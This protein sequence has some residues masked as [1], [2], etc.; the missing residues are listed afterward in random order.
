[1]TIV[2]KL[3]HDG[4]EI[5][6]MSDNLTQA[7]KQ[8]QANILLCTTQAG[9]GH[10]TSS[11]SAVHIMTSLFFTSFKFNPQDP[12]DLRNDRLIFSK[13]HASPLYYSLYRA[14]GLIAQDELMTF[15]KFGSRIEGH[16]SSA[17]PFC[18]CLTGS[19][20]Q[21]VGVA[22]GE[23]IALKKQG[24]DARVYCLLGDSELAEGSCY[25]AFNS[26]VYNKLDNLVYIVDFN[27]LGQRGATQLEHNTELL[28]KRLSSFGLEVF[29]LENGNNLNECLNTLH[30]LEF[31]TSSKPKVIIAKTQK[32]YGV[33]FLAD[34]E[35]FHGKALSKEDC[36]RALKEIGSVDMKAVYPTLLLESQE[37]SRENLPFKRQYPEDTK[38]QVQT[39]VWQTP[40]SNLSTRQAYGAYL[41]SLL[42]K[43]PAIMV[44][45]AEMSNST[46]TDIVS[47]NHPENFL[48]MF[49]AEQN[50]IS[51]ATGLA[52]L[53]FVPF[54]STFAAFLSRAYD[55]IRM[56]QYA[57]CCLNI[58]GS[59]CGI[60]IGPDGPSQM[61]LEDIAMFRSIHNSWVFY[62]CDSLS[63]CRLIDLM[64]QRSVKESGVNYL[65][66]TRDKGV[67]VYSGDKQFKVGGS[68]LLTQWQEIAVLTAGITIFE[69]LEVNK[70]LPI[71]VIDMYS[72]K[73]LDLEMLEQ[74][75]SKCSK[76]IVLEDHHLEGGLFEAIMATGKL[77]IPT[78][79]MA[80]DRL[81]KSGSKEEV[82]KHCKIDKDGLLEMITRIY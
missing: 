15:R 33:D 47:K 59:H 74:V 26:A 53:R 50:M 62:P 25:E 11:L 17:F 51:V 35:G 72:I 55:Q 30:Y 75:N 7:V 42:H 4:F 27:R 71:T 22:V 44:L 20:G 31:S 48:E 49:I 2:L 70:I 37:L 10:V 6:H 79:S 19:L 54:C 56:S 65:R 80:V 28:A 29:K 61:A 14:C 41:D 16:P 78:F 9:T 12:Y 43:N 67:D 82:M 58:A 5:F 77:E 69:A 1:L 46:Y 57:D 60:S 73:P 23:A 18:E 13:G 21:G 45:D 24:S 34:K 66:L 8:I 40:L 32:G 64:A 38:K 52:K 63:T 36:N 39:Y 68:H 81:P 76:V 3:C